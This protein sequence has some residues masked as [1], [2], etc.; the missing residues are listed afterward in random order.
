MNQPELWDHAIDVSPR[1]DTAQMPADA[2][3]KPTQAQRILQHLKSGKA[4]SPL[5]AL[6]KYGCFRLAA[7]I[8]ELR[9]AGHAIADTELTTPGGKRVAMYCMP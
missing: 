1:A 3:S 6:E 2:N 7:R 5:D 9:R 8:H 4:L